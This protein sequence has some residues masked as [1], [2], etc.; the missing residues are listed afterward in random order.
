MGAEAVRVAFRLGILVD[1]VSRNLHVCDSSGK[2]GKPESWAYVL[3]DVTAGEVQQELD[4]YHSMNV[5]SK[6]MQYLLS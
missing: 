6:F 3:P 5:S 2:T 1:E 4:L